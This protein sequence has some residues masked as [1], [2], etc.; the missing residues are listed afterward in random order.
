[1]IFWVRAHSLALAS[2]RE[3]SIDEQIILLTPSVKPG[4]KQLS[5]NLI[6]TTKLIREAAI[7]QYRKPISY[8]EYK[9][10]KSA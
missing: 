10:N 3:Q 6:S 8:V 1:M 2:K 4:A 5:A 7:G 9:L